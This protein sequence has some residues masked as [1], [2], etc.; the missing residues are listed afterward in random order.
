[1]DKADEAERISTTTSTG[2]T[3][4]PTKAPEATALFRS[5]V[6]HEELLRRIMALAP[7]N[8]TRTEMDIIV[9]L[10]AVGP[11]AMTPLSECVGVSKEHASRAVKSLVKREYIQR[12][13]DEANRRVIT[14]QLTGEGTLFLQRLMQDALVALEN[15]LAP[16]TIEQQK[17]LASLSHQADELICKAL[18]SKRNPYAKE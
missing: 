16:L 1:M 5:C 9:T 6:A 14:V 2:K 11:L 18:A 10:D 8:L 13:R 7:C 12:Q 17:Q 15:L 4:P 3:L